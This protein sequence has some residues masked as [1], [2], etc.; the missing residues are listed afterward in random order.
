[1]AELFNR[2]YELT[3]TY[4]DTILG[5]TS[6]FKIDSQI[7]PALDI[8]FNVVRTVNREP[9]TAE[10][11]IYNLNSDHRSFMETAENA[12]IELKAGYQ[13]DNG[14]IFRGDVEL[15]NIKNFPN[16]ETMFEADDGGKSVRFDRVN[17]S[18]AAGTSLQTVIQQL[19]GQMRVGIG[20][21]VQTALQG[22]LID[23]G[24]EFLNGVTLSGAASKQMNRLVKSSGLE[25]SIQ[26]GALQLLEKGKTLPQTAVVLNENT[27]LLGSPSVGNKG[28]LTVRSLLNKD[29]VPGGQ[30]KVE[31]SNV[32]GFFRCEKCTYIGVSLGNDWFVEVEAKPV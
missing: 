26:N 18:F 9:N 20:N 7:K 28:E 1:M 5:F 24:K 8:A 32:N 25:W 14:V 10:V 4:E 6:S 17:L 29:I 11:T 12:I 16:W 30:I 23:G 13:G 31:S 21:S 19:A 3:V 22:N 27:G 2:S 15:N